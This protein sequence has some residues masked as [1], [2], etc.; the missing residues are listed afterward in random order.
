MKRPWVVRD[1]ERSEWRWRPEAN[2]DRENLQ[3]LQWP[4]IYRI[5]PSFDLTIELQTAD[6]PNDQLDIWP[7][8]EAGR[9]GLVCADITNAICAFLDLFHAEPVDL[10]LFHKTRPIR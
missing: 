2:E 1:P 3:K 9:E 5:D 10:D 6:G 7:V 8:T 4:S